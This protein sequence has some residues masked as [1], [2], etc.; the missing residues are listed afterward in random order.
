MNYLKL[1]S[2]KHIRK[3]HIQGDPV[4]GGFSV[5]DVNIT[6]NPVGSEL[7]E[8]GLAKYEHTTGT[9]TQAAV[10]NNYS[11][12]VITDD[13]KWVNIRMLRDELLYKSDWT[14]SVDDHNLTAQQLTD[15]ETYRD[16]LKAI[17]DQSDVD[18][19]TWPTKP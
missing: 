8:S 9:N 4:P 15:W 10:H 14:R 18:A 6:D 1:D 12:Y 19:I 2:N 5:V 13:E 17:P 11:A 7:Y 16:D 3:E